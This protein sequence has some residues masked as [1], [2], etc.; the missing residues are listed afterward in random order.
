MEL[1]LALG[2]ELLGGRVDVAVEQLEAHP[3]REQPLLRA[4]VEVALQPPALLV[5]GA[6][7]PRPRIAQLDELGAE[8]GLQARVLQREPCGRAG[9]LEQTGL[10]DEVR[11]VYHDRE[12]L[13][14]T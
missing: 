14:E 12:P 13:A 2:E 1:V 8:L 7:D 4:V 10:V 9:R 11:V 5:A 3:E 6:D